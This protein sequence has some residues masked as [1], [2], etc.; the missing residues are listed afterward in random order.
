MAKVNSIFE[1]DEFKPFKARWDERLKELSRRKR[2]YDGTIYRSVRDQVGWLW[3]RLYKGIKPLFLPLAR[4]VDV[5]AGIIPGEWAL[6]EDAPGAWQ[7]AIDQVFDWSDWD[8]DGVL[9]VHFGAQYGLSGLKISDLRQSRRVVI[10]P[11]SPTTFLLIETG[12]YDDRPTMAIIVEKRNDRGGKEYEYAEVVTAEQIRTFKDGQPLGF[13][14]REPEYINELKFVP[15]VEIRHIETGELMGEATYQKAIPMLDEVNQLASY[16]ADVIGK[17]AEP[18]WVVMGAEAGD[19]VKSGD[20]VWFVPDG[21]KVEALVPEVDLP[22]ILEFIREIR[23]QVHGSLPELAFDELRKKDQI[24]TATLELQLM[25]LVLKIKRCRPNYDHGL[26]DALRMA[27]LAG[28]SMGIGEVA[29]LDDEGLAFDSK[30]AVLPMD[31][32]TEM[33][34]EMQRLNLEQMQALA[35]V[36]PGPG[37]EGGDNTDITAEQDGGGPNG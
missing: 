4:A 1:V 10:K 12:D 30:R 8:R 3:P 37:D 19:L 23:D 13:D 36:E 35:G 7:E 6:A 26:A 32:I 22:G 16:L 9:Y 27:G 29:A 34:I 21:A 25:E 20:N 31:P 24:A 18:Q 33:S 17:H 11:I 5:D 2:Y 28:K 15:V 14:G